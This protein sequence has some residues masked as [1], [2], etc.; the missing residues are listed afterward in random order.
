MTSPTGLSLATCRLG[1]GCSVVWAMG[2]GMQKVWGR[3]QKAEVP[4]SY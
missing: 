4:L 3:P 1:C 2:I